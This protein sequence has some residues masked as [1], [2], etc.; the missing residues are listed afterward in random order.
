[1]LADGDGLELSMTAALPLISRKRQRKRRTDAPSDFL[2]KFPLQQTS[3]IRAAWIAKER[4]EQVAQ[5]EALYGYL[6]SALGSPTRAATAGKDSPVV[7]YVHSLHC[8]LQRDTVTRLSRK[9]QIDL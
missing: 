7:G 2:A 5:Y 4:G 8:A 3:S 9:T 6:G 1:V